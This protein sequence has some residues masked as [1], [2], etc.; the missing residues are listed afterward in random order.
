M[1]FISGVS[2]PVES[3][4]A[5]VDTIVTR[6]TQS[7]YNVYPITATGEKRSAMIKE[8]NPDAIVYFPMG[9]LGNDS[10]LNWVYAHKIPLS[11]LSLLPR[12][13]RNG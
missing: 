5:H 12:H 2:F 10:L 4:R 8:V 3:N 1:A 6:L 9:R 13:S 11:C 7:G